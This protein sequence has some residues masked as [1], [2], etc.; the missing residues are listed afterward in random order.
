MS[1]DDIGEIVAFVILAA[2][3]FTGFVVVEQRKRDAK[4]PRGEKGDS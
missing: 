4:S 1:W 3:Y 2:L